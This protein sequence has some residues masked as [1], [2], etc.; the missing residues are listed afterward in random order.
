VSVTSVLAPRPGTIGHSIIEAARRFPER[1]AYIFGERQATHAE[2][3]ERTIECARSLLGHGVHPGDQVGILMPNGWSYPILTG[4]INLIGACAVV[5]N[6][7]YRGEDLKYVVRH[8][9]IS[10]LL[11]TGGA[12]PR[13][14]LRAMLCE[15]FPE[16]AQWRDGT[17]CSLADAPKLCKVFH[18]D[19]PDEASW[20]AEASFEAAARTIGD[21]ELANLVAAVAPD[22]IAMII[23]S[24]GTTAR[25]KACMVSHRVLGSVSAGIAERL[26]IGADDVFWDPLPFYHLS[27]HLPLNACRQVGAAFVSQSHFEAAS[28][29][30]EMER[31][32]ATICYPAFP[33]LTAAIIDH[34]E[35]KARDLSR[36]RLMVNIGA[37]EL[38]R[39]FAEAIPQAKQI[40][41][42]GL[43]EGGG[44]ST[45][46]SPGDTLEERISRVGRPLRNQRIRIVDPE[47]LEDRPPGERGEILLTGACFS[48]YFKDEDQTMEV[49]LPGGW[50]RSG[51]LGWID[52]NGQLA[53]AGRRKDMLKIGGENVAAVEV[54]SFLARHPK[55]KMA[56]VIP[57]PDPRLTEVAA[58]HIELKAGETMTEAEVIEYCVDQIA[59][60]KVPRYVRFVNEWPMS[61]TKVQKF[62]LIEDFV[63]YGKIDVDAFRRARG[64]RSSETA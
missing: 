49:M 39:K 52:G 11:T 31:V 14:D 2:Y 35:F 48:G 23:F 58:A 51:D 7:R 6:A 57:A 33:A 47:T 43:T 32:R 15:Q 3:A 34:P 27:S 63:P 64:R 18:F 16:L 54:E 50:L 5:L 10:L 17:A 8:A 38:L 40:S 44:I 56:V 41:C 20:P 60:Y 24:S 26:E 21:E 9:E 22:D 25:P 46:S 13:L 12:R 30:A 45:M 42:Y 29:L 55:V 37:P 36:L 4:A 19:A 62:K 61:A 1:T 59:S 28:A 53:F